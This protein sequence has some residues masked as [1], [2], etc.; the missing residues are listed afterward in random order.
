ME[1]VARRRAARDFSPPS[2]DEREALRQYTGWG[3]LANQ[4]LD[5]RVVG[6]EDRLHRIRELIGPEGLSAITAGVKNAHYTSYDVV[7]FGWDAAQKLGFR[8]GHVLE[9]AAGVGN[10]LGLAPASLP[11]QFLAV[12]LD[13]LSADITRLLYPDSQVLAS[14]FERVEGWRDRFDLAF[15]NVPFG[16]YRP[17]CSMGDPYRA[18]KPLIH[19]YFIL[20]QLDMIR[21]GGLCV[22]IT[23]KGTLDKASGRIREMISSKADLVAAYRLPESTFEKNADTSVTADLLIL[24]KRPPNE[25]ARGAAFARLIPDPASGLRI[26][27]YFVRHPENMFGKMAEGGMLGRG[28]TRLVGV[29]A[30]E[31]PRHFAAALDRLQPLDLPEPFTGSKEAGPELLPCPQTLRMGELLYHEGKFCSVVAKGG[32]TEIFVSTEARPELRSALAIKEKLRELL[33]AQLEHATDE[34]LGSLQANLRGLVG[35]HLERFCDLEN[36][37]DRKDGGHSPL[38]TPVLRDFMESDPDYFKVISLVD[39]GIRYSDIFS[40]RTVFSAAYQ[41]QPPGPDATLEEITL[42]VRQHQGVVDVAEIARLKGISEGEA[43]QALLEEGIAYANPG[44]DRLVHRIEYLAGDDVYAKLDAA[45]GG[46]STNPALFRRNVEALEKIIPAKIPLEE[47]CINSRQPIYDAA[48]L[49]AFLC[50]RLQGE[51]EVRRFLTGKIEVEGRSEEDFAQ[52][53]AN[54]SYSRSFAAHANRE[55]LRVRGDSRGDGREL[56]AEEWQELQ[57]RRQAQREFEAQTSRDFEAWIK[58]HPDHPLV[59]AGREGTVREHVE[60]VYNRAFNRSVSPAY[61]GSRLRFQGIAGEMNGQPLHLHKHNLDFAARMLF[62]G[63]G[64]NAHCV[65]AGK[66][67]AGSLTAKAWRQCGMARKPAFIVP[68]KVLRKWAKEYSGLFPGDHLLVIDRFD[69]ANREEM[70]SRIAV[71]SPDAIFMTHEHAK[72]IPNDPEAESRLIGEELAALR[73]QLAE[74]LE[75]KVSKRTLRA[76]ENAIAKFDARL[77]DLREYA[78]TNRIT[79]AE[80]GIDALIVDEAHNYKNLPVQTKEQAS[81]IPSGSSQRAFDL[82]LK[83]RQILEAHQDRGVLLLSATPVSNT[84]AEIY[85]MVKFVA[86]EAWTSRGIRS[87]DNWIDMFGEIVTKPQV[88]VDGSFGIRSSLSSFRNLPEL[89]QIFETFWEAR[90]AEHLQLK[91]PTAEIVVRVVEPSPEQ[92]RYFT[93]IVERAEAIRNK[94]VEPFEDNMLKLTVDGRKA[95]LDLR[96]V[97]ATRYRDFGDYPDSKLQVVA[98]E[99]WS[100]YADAREAGIEAGQLVFFDLYAGK[101]L[102]EVTEADERSLAAAEP[103]NGEEDTLSVSEAPSPEM[104]PAERGRASLDL[105]NE[106]AKLLVRR[107][108]P[109]SEIAILNGKQNATATAKQLVSDRYNEGVL[110]VV[111]GTTPAMG[112]GMNLQR[113][114]TAIHHADVPLKPSHMEQRDGRGLRQ[115]NL[116]TNLE[117]L[118]YT[119]RGSFDQ[120]LYQLLERKARFITTFL[121]G[122]KMER[123]AEGVSDAVVLSY[124]EAMGATARDPRVRDYFVSKVKLAQAEVAV[125]GAEQEWRSLK[126]QARDIA[127]SIRLCEERTVQAEKRLIARDAVLKELLGER[128]DSK[129]LPESLPLQ[130][131]MGEKSVSEEKA[132]GAALDEVLEK[133]LTGD[134]EHPHWI[135]AVKKEIPGG[136]L[137]LNGIRFVR[138]LVRGVELSMFDQDVHALVREGS[139]ATIPV[140]EARTPATQLMGNVRHEFRS[141]ERTV[142]VLRQ[143]RESLESGKRSGERRLATAEKNLAAGQKTCQELRGKVQALATEVGVNSTA[144]S[145][146]NAPDPSVPSPARAIARGASKLRRSRPS[147]GVELEP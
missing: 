97:D 147:R 55:P 88:L 1:I 36:L 32:M 74:A 5:P 73:E 102:Q 112:E 4:F 135:I 81:G 23:G 141:M 83:S 145:H 128:F 134:K 8:G 43:R 48:L 131:V 90:T 65:G 57:A 111:I 108:M 129:T 3:G 143:E 139:M 46:V 68:K 127:L 120:Y 106:L 71:S 54:G 89:K 61:D 119:T 85:N 44:D 101:A 93:E 132:I 133:R 14:A 35:Q 10:I 94:E 95:A 7:K 75:A 27:E 17:K 86:P 28:G 104:P 37:E 122:E 45:R 87:F 100:R 16:D 30:H 19:D 11:I 52:G 6:N 103:E 41:P 58:D 15:T 56:T 20:R 22:V 76:I 64:G 60:R 63:R 107:G 21:P 18:M 25:W 33:S 99:V 77:N 13:P 113:I 80:T 138:R 115:G 121:S 118:R 79:F 53:N 34:G 29:E 123:S 82:Y 66:T 114:T 96:L 78:R 12:E 91:R 24:R 38:D 50:D 130:L 137:E 72:M 51:F 116:H 62:E 70:L 26:N 2:P 98:D 110:R 92:G 59:A 42:F 105:H 144:R 84:M 136:A 49:Q 124:E 47:L 146:G 31:L 125:K 117:I 40:T 39:R 67:F 142:E 140:M 109:P 126:S 69:K 9:P